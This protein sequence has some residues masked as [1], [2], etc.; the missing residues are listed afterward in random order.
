[1][2]LI[3]GESLRDRLLRSPING[4]DAAKIIQQVA[5][6]LAIAHEA[7]LIHRD[8]K[9]ANILLD[10]QD[11][12]AKLADFGL[13]RTRDDATLTQ[14]DILCGTPEYMS[15]EQAVNPGKDGHDHRSDIYSLG[16]TLYE[17]LAGIPPFRGEPLAIIDQHRS[18][19]PIRPSRLNPSI[20][21]D[22]ETI[23]LRA[24]SKQPD[25]RFPTAAAMAGRSAAIS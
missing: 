20:P 25:R 9:P 22:L 5:Q 6:G 12:Q 1:M 18:V 14:H 4:R 10:D 7:G 24:I 11:G 3:A 21:R 19:E 8:I 17:C 23:C 13:V 16:V 2:P 15:P